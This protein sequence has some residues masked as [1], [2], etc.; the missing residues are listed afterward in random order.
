MKKESLSAPQTQGEAVEEFHALSVRFS[1]PYLAIQWHDIVPDWL[2]GK[3]PEHFHLA[4][5]RS[6]CELLGFYSI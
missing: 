5:R 4:C 1:Q 6:E 2:S 3:E